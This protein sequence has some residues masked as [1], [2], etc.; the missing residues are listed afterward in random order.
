MNIT[1]SALKRI[2]LEEVHDL[3]KMQGAMEPSRPDVRGEYTAAGDCDD[4]FF[5]ILLGYL[6]GVE[7]S[8]QEFCS[9]AR[10]DRPGDTLS[11]AMREFNISPD[12]E[13]EIRQ[14]YEHIYG[15]EDPEYGADPEQEQWMNEE[16]STMSRMPSDP[17]EV[18]KCKAG[19]HRC[20]SGGK[21]TKKACNH[22]VKG[23]GAVDI[24]EGHDKNHKNHKRKKTMKITKNRL[25]RIILEEYKKIEEARG[26]R[27]A[28]V[29]YDEGG[30]RVSDGWS[31]AQEIAFLSFEDIEGTKDDPKSGPEIEGIVLE[32]FDENGVG[33]IRDIEQDVSDIDPREWLDTMLMNHPAGSSM[34]PPK[35]SSDGHSVRDLDFINDLEGR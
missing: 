18:K 32:F 22:P 31:P 3:L 11:M 16:A 13:W 33:S 29:D 17:G 4:N 21:C 9:I 23:I 15:Q 7:E 35:G 20:T 26:G 27:T 34:R 19:Q 2:I 28:H 12:A 10:S 1:R 14:A 30:I 6:G 24:H 5:G 8:C 25:K